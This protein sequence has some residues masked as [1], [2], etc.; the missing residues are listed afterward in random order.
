MKRP[1]EY[2]VKE[3]QEMNERIGRPDA[4]ETKSKELSEPE[5]ENDGG[6]WQVKAVRRRPF[7][8]FRLIHLS[9]FSE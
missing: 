8:P 1:Q 6:D 4:N 3:W 5:T 9:L 7:V 2:L